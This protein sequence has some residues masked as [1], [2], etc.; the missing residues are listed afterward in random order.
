[1]SAARLVA[2]ALVVALLAAPSARAGSQLDA[3]LSREPEPTPAAQTRDY[4]NPDLFLALR[5]AI[6]ALQDLGF[7]LESADSERGLI[8]ASRLDTHAL[9][10]T[11]RLTA[12]D[13]STV[14]A[15]VGTDYRNVPIA[16]P[17]PA[18]AFFSAFGRAL[19][20]PAEID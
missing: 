3:I 7:A 8:S 13:E 12:P 20:P 17:R 4:E 16:D 11:V 10:L 5:A 18:E 19:A 9:R 2:A 1:M 6:G 15:T 14:T